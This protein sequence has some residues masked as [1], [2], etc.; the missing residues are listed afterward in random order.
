[1]KSLKQWIIVK[2]VQRPDGKTDKLP[3][4]H[5]TLQMF[6]TG[7]NWQQDPDAWTSYEQAI[8]LTQ[9]AGP[10]YGI[11]FLFTPADPFFFL[12][13]DNCLINNVPSATAVEMVGRFPGAAVEVSQSGRGL[14]IFG[15]YTGPEPAH[16]CKNI[17]LSI[18][19]YTSGRFAAI[20]GDRAIGDS[21]TDCTMALSTLIAERFTPSEQSVEQQWTT[22][23]AP[24]YTGPTDDNEL[25]NRAITC[26]STAGQFSGKATFAQLWTNDVVTLSQ[27]WPTEDD[28][29]YDYSSADAAL[30]QHLAFWTGNNCERILSLMRRSALSR[31]KWERED[32][33]RRTILRAV[34]GQRQIYS[35]GGQELD[36]S[37]LTGTEKQIAFAA[38]IR[39]ALIDQYPALS[40]ITSAK[41]WIENRDKTGPE[42]LQMITPVERSLPRPV[43]GPELTAGYQLLGVE[44]QLN[45]FRGCVY[46][47]DVHRIFTPS[48]ALLKPEQFNATYGG[49][50]FESGSGDNSKPTK[51]AWDAFTESQLVRYPIAESTCFRP[52]EPPGALVEQDGRYLVNTYIPVITRRTVGDP[53]PFLRHL[54]LVLPDPN[55]QHIMLSYMAACVQLKGIKFQ[56]APLIQGAPGNG[57]SL[58][59]R[60][61]IN[62]IGKKYAHKPPAEQISEKFNDWLFNRVF[63]GVEDIYIPSERRDLVQLL[64]PM[65]TDEWQACR[66]MQVGQVMR[67]CCAN[68][69]FNSNHK[70][71]VQKTENDRR[72]CI[73]YCP[74]QTKTDIETDGMGGDYFPNLY[75]WL[76]E[77]DGYAIVTDYLY[78]FEISDSFK[79][80]LMY[81]APQT[82]STGEAIVAGMGAVEQKILDMIEEG[83]PGFAGGWISSTALDNMLKTLRRDMSI[84]IN[85]RR[86]MLQALGYDWHPALRNGRVNN[87]VLPDNGKP[88]L[89]IK[90]G[91][92][93]EQIR[94]A[95][96]VA[97]VY[98]ESQMA[99]TTCPFNQSQLSGAAK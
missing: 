94:D 2:Y 3:V 50:L 24:G 73:F 91:H 82:S 72:F 88:K 28:R 44:Q 43:D 52:T 49:Y 4:D 80:T 26:V 83:I 11:G 32:Y 19:L 40:V 47:Q 5:R 79:K 67:D 8:T 25:I 27:V 17:P 68:F 61:V 63:I 51:K 30:A 53:G 21:R 14:H 9:L 36:R 78:R 35:V 77:Q 42:L 97:R 65:I 34:S 48:G 87:L 18:E 71:A 96:T 6:T 81:R 70:D 64:L 31:D 98:T 29:D 33:L 92:L 76:K 45:H 69:I 99:A 54:A 7:S 15:N 55:D 95:A 84:P 10:G 39:A 62:A 59:T 66:A 93:A 75:D 56:W 85:K 60:C 86:E 13:I 38:A 41:M 74:Q 12:D 89:F 20:T 90:K 16:C 1:M 57:K 37:G 58:F 46:V 23:P 22:G